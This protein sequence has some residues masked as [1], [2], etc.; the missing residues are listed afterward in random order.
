MTGPWACGLSVRVRQLSSDHALLCALAV[1][2]KELDNACEVGEGRRPTA[3]LIV[4][5]KVYVGAR[6]TGDGWAGR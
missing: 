3:S 4:A 6:G 5:L 2:A 1:F